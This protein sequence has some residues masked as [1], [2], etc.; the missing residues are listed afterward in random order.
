MKRIGGTGG[1]CGCLDAR[2]GGKY[3]TDQEIDCG[4]GRNP[5]HGFEKVPGGGGGSM[6]IQGETPRK[7][8]SRQP[9]NGIGNVKPDGTGHFTVNDD[10]QLAC[11]IG[12][13]RPFF[14]DGTF[15]NDFVGSRGQVTRLIGGQGG[16]GGA[17]LTESYYCG[18]W[19]DHDDDP[20]NDEVCSGTDF[21]DPPSRGDS[22]G[23][24]RGGG[25]G[26]GGGALLIQALGEITLDS[27]A[28]IDAHG[29]AGAGGEAIGCSYWGG[30]GGGGA[31]G[32]ILLQSGSDIFVANGAK[33]DVTAGAGDDAENDNHYFVCDDGTPEGDPGDAGA[34]G[35]GLIQLQV[36]AG[37]TATVV[38]PLFSLHPR[39][40]WLDSSNTLNPAEFTPISVA[41][42]AWYD[43]GRVI[44]RPPADTNPVF[45]F[46]GLDAQGLVDVDA[47]GN[48]TAPDTSDIV[49]G[50]L[51]QRDPLTN[52]KEYKK[53]EEPRGHFVPTNATIKV[54]F[55][56]AN[57]IVDGS[58][59]VD[60]GSLTM[61]SPTPSIADAHQFL[62]WRITFDVTADGS[63]L[64][65]STRL[66]SVQRVRVRGSF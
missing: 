32:M 49:V 3:Q 12:G 17:S 4:E 64:T 2:D 35:A 27:T 51:G 6:L 26:A 41:L 39:E 1:Q 48:V 47:S 60:P 34:G 61:W 23:D 53:G 36:P 37:S 54:E 16:G 9:L 62:R 18:V 59:E 44:T 50:Y 19:C 11:G 33:L 58:K 40:S 5:G 65:P 45:A 21:G 7:K 22:V 42:S 55:Q 31:G 28:T 38:N 46:S 52:Y 43:M 25:A 57:A 20:K 30:G 63:Q 56:G 13:L 24:A 29:G 8:T 14:D 66:P 10:V 15:A